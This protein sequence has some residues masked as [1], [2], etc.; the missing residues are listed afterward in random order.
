MG[1]C[2]TGLQDSRVGGYRKCLSRKESGVQNAAAFAVSKLSEGKGEYSF[3][4]SFFRRGRN[5]DVSFQVVRAYA[6]IAAGTTY[7]LL[8]LLINKENNKSL[9]AFAVT[10]YERLPSHHH[11][12]KYVV[13]WGMQVRCSKAESLMKNRFRHYGWDHSD[14][15]DTSINSTRYFHGCH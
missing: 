1:L 9:G 4:L 14:F 11:L 15:R 6:Q 8:I 5:D 7:R 3:D 13:I 10:V 12:G 2:P